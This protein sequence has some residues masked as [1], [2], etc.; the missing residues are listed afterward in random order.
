MVRMKSLIKKNFFNVGVF[1]STRADY[2]LLRPLLKRLENHEEFD[3]KVFATGT[4]L[5]KQ[6]GNTVDI[7]KEHSYKIIKEIHIPIDNSTPER[8]CFNM[9]DSFKKFSEEISGENIELMIILGDR[10]ESFVMASVCYVMRIP[11][12]HI[13]GGEVTEGAYDEGFRHSIT[14]MSAVHFASCEEH[15]KRIVQL[16][17]NP[18]TVFNVGALGIENIV[19]GDK[20]SLNE[21]EEI[22]EMDLSGGYALSTCHPETLKGKGVD[23]IRE[24]T[25]ALEGFEN[26]KV[27]FTASNCDTGGDLVNEEI[28]ELVRRNRDR[29]VFVESLGMKNYLGA[30]E[31][32]TFVIGNSSS[33][34]LEV[35][36]FHKP[37]INIGDRQK[38]RVDDPFVINVGWDSE[39]IKEIIGDI[40]EGRFDY[41]KNYIGKFG[42]GET[43]N[44]MVEI[45]KLKLK[46][47]ELGRGKSFYD[48]E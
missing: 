42:D 37:C 41:P 23:Y 30:V 44:R 5:S 40:I 21:I 2:G 1:T 38:G 12:C 18:R 24:L 47:G 45:L 35:P 22:L 28:K 11:I 27:I 32:C 6:H 4:H 7:I 14:K 39:K 15:R 46:E 34:V 31:N 26:L 13:H 9:G 20:A 8:T 3:L 36:A 19:K 48:L 43:S 33:G 25:K 16:G 17:E 29:M 10:Y